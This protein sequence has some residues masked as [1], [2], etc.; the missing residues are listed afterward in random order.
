MAVDR[1][2]KPWRGPLHGLKVLDLTRVLAG[3]FATQI[4]GDL[5]ARVL[6][7]ESLPNGDETRKFRP[8]VNGESHYFLSINRSKSSLA[9]DHRKP[10]GA[11]IIRR[12]AAQ[13]DI[14]VENFRPGVMEHRGLGYEE[15]KKINPRLIYCSISGFGMTGPLKDFPSFDL[16][17][18]AWTGALSINGEA[19][20]NPIKLG[21]PMGDLVGGIFG[22]IGILSVLQ[23][24]NRTG[25]GRL[26]D[27]S[28]FDGLIG[29]LGYLPQLAFATG[30]NPKPVGSGHPNLTPYGVYSAKDGNIA[31]A[32]LTEGFWINLCKAL[33]RPDL[34]DDPR[35]SAAESRTDNR[36]ELDK[37]ISSVT[38][39]RS[40]DE[41][42][43]ILTRGDVPNAPIL[44]I[45]EA[46]SHPQ[47]LARDLIQECHHPIAGDIKLVGR[48]LKF[49]GMNEEPLQPPPTLGQHT[50]DV[51]AE[52]LNYSPSEIETLVRE[53]VISI[54]P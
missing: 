21:L 30:S 51:L 52:E 29:L 34:I 45:L 39:T 28:L 26:I 14:L 9:V 25:L 5:G 3:P 42:R 48:P 33:E 13:S 50:N 44:G 2:P 20:G 32:C 17:T 24:R 46:L 12:L 53:G 4:L 49:P 40:V 37:I 6:K 27:V 22:A 38:R 23:E 7:I 35:F 31:I 43:D 41:L 10:Q 1:A 47:A 18:Q 15:L 19:G 11:A 54:S 36:E 8:L 16:V